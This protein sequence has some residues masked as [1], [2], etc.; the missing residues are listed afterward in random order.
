MGQ[1][2]SRNNSIDRFSNDF[3]LIIRATK[4]L[5]FILES[6]FG[7]PAND[8]TVGLHEKI[9]RARC[10]NGQPLPDDVVRQLRYLVTIRNRLV[11]DRSFNA[12][13]DRPAFVASFDKTVAQ[14]TALA[15]A[16]QRVGSDACAVM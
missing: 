8:K 2:S 9:S 10:R 5:E 3:E 4:E 12:I 14:L 11:H 16:N 6:H 13:P 7:V 15:P 1:S